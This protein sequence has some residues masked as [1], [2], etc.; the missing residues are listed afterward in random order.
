MIT[1]ARIRR[2][3]YK[4]GGITTLRQKYGK[5]TDLLRKLI[6]NELARVAEVAAPIAAIVNPALAPWAA[7]AAGLG[8]YDRTGKLGS[9][10]LYGGAIYGGGLAADKFG[11]TKFLA[12]KGFDTRTLGSTLQ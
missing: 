9:S 5:G 3:L 12:G 6:P 10:A 1:R 4:G 7:A 11:A 2:Q 8:R